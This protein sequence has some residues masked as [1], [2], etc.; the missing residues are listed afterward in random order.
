MDMAEAVPL[1]GPGVLS[2]SYPATDGLLKL[3]TFMSP[4]FP[5]GSFAYSHG[6]EWLIDTG[7]ITDANGLREWL[8]DLLEIGSL[9]VDAVLFAAAYRAS[10]AEDWAELLAV[11][12]LAE[13]LAT[14]R[15]RHLETTAQGHA[16]LA[17]AGHAWPCEALDRLGVSDGTAYPVAVAA[18]AASHG[19]PLG[20]ALSAYLNAAVANLVSVGV[21]LV[22]LGQTAGLQVLAALHPVMAASAEAAAKA[23]LEDFGSATVLSDIAAMRH[24]EQYSRVFRT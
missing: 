1:G 13:A 2:P 9:R 3:L 15:E 6:L 24:E 19:I 12:E 11:S 5:V 17:A 14:S 8:T 16:F 23:S 7:R 20:L 21:R 22:P 18:A 10:E 4:G